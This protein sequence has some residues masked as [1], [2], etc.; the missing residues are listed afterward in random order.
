MRVWVSAWV[1]VEGRG[2]AWDVSR[3]PSPSPGSAC[4]RVPH[5]PH[6]RALQGLELIIAQF[7]DLCILMG[8]DYTP[9]R[10][11][12]STSTNVTWKVLAEGYTMLEVILH[13][14]TASVYV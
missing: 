7:V 11:R 2:Q 14:D 5:P 1:W 13:P 8:C 12:W 3:P 6:R 4:Y 10:S 9:T